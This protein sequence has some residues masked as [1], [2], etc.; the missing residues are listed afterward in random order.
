MRD[1]IS[2]AELLM[3]SGLPLVPLV[4]LLLRDFISAASGIGH[5]VLLDL[6]NDLHVLRQ[7]GSDR[8]DPAQKRPVDP[9]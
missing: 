9:V 8:P 5:I 7:L 2:H 3:E 1:I 4:L 6:L